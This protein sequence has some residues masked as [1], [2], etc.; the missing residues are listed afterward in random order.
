MGNFERDINGLF[1]KTVNAKFATLNKMDMKN[2]SQLIENMHLNTVLSVITNYLSHLM[3][4]F[5][6][7]FYLVH[8]YKIY[9][10]YPIILLYK[11]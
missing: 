10:T 2:Y 4:Y 6:I 3:I 8:Q 1:G 9:F 11:I 7:F 5:K